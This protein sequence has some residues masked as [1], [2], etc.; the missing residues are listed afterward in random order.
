M[1][2]TV[3][4]SLAVVESEQNLWPWGQSLTSGLIRVRTGHCI[5][6]SGPYSDL[7]CCVALRLVTTLIWVSISA[8]GKQKDKIIFL[9]VPLDSS[10]VY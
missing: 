1:P 7:R 4:H 8:L 9:K 6:E 2:R 5:K 3:Q 10:P